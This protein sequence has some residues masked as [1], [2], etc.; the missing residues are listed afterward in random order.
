MRISFVAAMSKNR[1]IGKGNKIPWNMPADLKHMRKLTEGKPLIMGRKTHESIGRPLPNRK[2]IILTRDKNYKSEG[3]IV[4]NTQV[5]ALKAAEGSE[6]IIIF[7]GE[8]IYKIFLPSAD[9][10]YLTI[11]DALIEGDAFF[12]E[13]K[14]EEW[15][16]VSREK[17]E[18]DD[19]NPYDYVFLVLDRV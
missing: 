2:N 4:V 3:C 10:M 1:V 17:H 13:Y 5:E 15:K 9:R 19:K 6:E 12:P 8:D 11:I 16:E 18:K 14:K 7:G